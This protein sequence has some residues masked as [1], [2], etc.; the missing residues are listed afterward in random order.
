MSPMSRLLNYSFQQFVDLDD[1]NC[2]FLR[3]VAQL[4]L[5]PRI[6]EF[7]LTNKMHY[8]LTLLNFLLI[9]K[10]LLLA[11]LSVHPQRRLFPTFASIS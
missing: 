6:I 11:P 8:I 3:F 4:L 10:M 1:Y 7:Q 9:S 2:T 5:I